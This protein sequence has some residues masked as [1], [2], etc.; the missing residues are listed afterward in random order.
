ME[1]LVWKMNQNANARGFLI[2]GFPRTEMQYKEF[3][4]LVSFNE[5]QW[6]LRL[7]VTRVNKLELIF[8]F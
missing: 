2:D 5:W 1:S 7:L 4:N 3:K 6:F 8:Q